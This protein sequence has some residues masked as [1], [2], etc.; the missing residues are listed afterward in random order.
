M[1]YNKF[2]G[3]KEIEIGGRKFAVSRIPALEA[4][5]YVYPAVAK[6]VQ[7][8]GLLGTTM[9]DTAVVREILKYTAV[10]QDDGSFLELD[11]DT[12]IN[13]TFSKNFEDM[14][15]LVVAM[16]RENFGF[17]TDGNLHEVLG[18]VEAETG[19]DS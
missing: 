2:I 7:L 10:R 11:I 15:R 4:Q 1:D 9:L 8:N 6:C 17:L 14:A 13:D 5:T 12:R 18:I 19:S 16:I 3:A